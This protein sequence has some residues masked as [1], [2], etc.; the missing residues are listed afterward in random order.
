MRS[1]KAGASAARALAPPPP[2]AAQAQTDA[3]VAALREQPEAIPSESAADQLALLMASLHLVPRRAV[4]HIALWDGDWNDPKTWYRGQIPSEGARVLIPDGVHVQIGALLETRIF[5]LRVDG[6]LEFATDVDSRIVFDTLVVTPTGSLLIGTELDPVPESVTVDLLIADNGTLDPA[7]DP[8]RLSRGIV[9]H[10]QT[11]IHGTARTQVVSITES[12]RAGDSALSLGAVPEDWQIGDTI[13]IASPAQTSGAGNAEARVIADLDA[14][15][16]YF[17]EPLF[18]D[19][20]CPVGRP[21]EVFNL[22]RSISIET[23]HA[24]RV[25]IGDRGHILL[26]GSREISMRFA[27]LHELGR[28]EAATDERRDTGNGHTR[29]RW[30]GRHPLQIIRDGQAIDATALVGGNTYWRSPGQAV[31]LHTGAPASADQPPRTVTDPD[32]MSISSL[33]I[34]WQECFLSALPRQ[35]RTAPT[36]ERNASQVSLNAPVRVSAGYS[37]H[38]FQRAASA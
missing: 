8:A 12:V 7:W 4:T 26:A 11:I 2:E 17:D 14:E 20:L 13:V 36:I 25:R 27:E 34:A 24:H 3:Y 19:H 38:Y 6:E 35:R 28:P 23:E 21:C 30:Q 33:G 9:S 22:A 31:A 15:T 32:G 37:F 5:T 18:S 29:L 10:G 1:R 16:V